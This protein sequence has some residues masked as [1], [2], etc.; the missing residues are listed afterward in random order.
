MWDPPS[1]LFFLLNSYEVFLFVGFDSCIACLEL[2][3]IV[4][5]LQQYLFSTATVNI[6]P[7][8]LQEMDLK[9]ESRIRLIKIK[10]IARWRKPTLQQ[11]HVTITSLLVSIIV[12]LPKSMDHWS[13]STTSN[14]Q[15]SSPSLLLLFNPDR[16]AEIVNVIL[17]DGSVRKGQVLEIA[18]K[19]AVVQVIIS[20]CSWL[21]NI[22]SS[23]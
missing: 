22:P 15:S 6:A 18:G 3:N 16:Y 13:L 7:R 21:S 5:L 10:I 12:Q 19:K 17:G 8:N 20:Q 1:R 23:S 2:H 14:S 11:W 9:G 4:L